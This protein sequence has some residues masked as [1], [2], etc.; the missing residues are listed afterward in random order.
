[1]KDMEF[2]ELLEKHL[3]QMKWNQY[4]IEKWQLWENLSN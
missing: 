4:G 3:L 2:Q 1:M